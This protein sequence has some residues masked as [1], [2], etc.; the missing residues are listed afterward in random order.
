MLPTKLSL[1]TLGSRPGSSYKTK[2]SG[3]N[4]AGNFILPY[5]TLKRNG[6]AR[7]GGGQATKNAAC[8]KGRPPLLLWKELCVL[9]GIHLLFAGGRGSRRDGR[10]SA[11]TAPRAEVFG[12]AAPAGR[13]VLGVRESQGQES[14]ARV[15]PNAYQKKRSPRPGRRRAW[16]RAAAAQHLPWGIVTTERGP[17][18]PS[19]ALQLHCRCHRACS[20]GEGASQRG[21]RRRFRRSEEA[22][23]NF[24]AAEI[25]PQRPGASQQALPFSRQA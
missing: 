16:L 21:S 15:T 18:L 2:R 4:T 22:E 6:A 12:A 25:A 23:L 17:P 9:T 24:A 19:Y 11:G 14:A 10:P 20:L 5:A 1:E 13:I 7:A 8:R 3:P